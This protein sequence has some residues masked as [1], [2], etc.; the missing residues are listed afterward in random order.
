MRAP[1]LASL[2][3]AV[4]VV[5][6]LGCTATAQP[7]SNAAREAPNVKPAGAK[8]VTVA[9]TADPYTLSS[10]V[11]AA[12]TGIVPGLDQIEQLVHTG[13]A[14]VAANG[15]AEPVIAEA[16]PTVE[17]G[18][19][20]LLPD[21]RMETT[22]T[23]R[24]GAT[25]HDGTPFT[26]DDL[27]FTADVAGD[28]DLP[29][30]RDVAQK[31]IE[32]VSARD[33]R[34]ITVT[35]NRP[36]V[37]A[38]LMFT[39]ALA[40]PLPKHLLQ[41][42]YADDKAALF[43]NPYFSTEFVGAGPFKIQS[44]ERDSY[45]RLTA[46]DGY[47]LGRPKLDEIEVRFFPDPNALIAGILAGAVDV[48]LGRGLSVD[49]AVQIRDQWADGHMDVALWAP[50]GMYPQQL[51][52][53]PAILGDA[54]FRR[55]LVHAIDR[56][57]M[58][59]T[60]VAGQSP[61]AHSFL[62]PDEAEYAATERSVVRYDYDARR[63]AQ[64]LDGLGL[65]R[66]QDGMYRNSDGSELALEIR[67]VISTDIN[68]KSMLAIADY[69]QRAGLRTNTM[70]IPVS[71]A[72]EREFRATFPGFDL[73]GGVGGNY[74]WL[75][76]LYSSQVPTSETRWVGRNKARYADPAL[77]RLIDRFFATV[78][79]TERMD[80]LN[81]IVH[82]LTDQV[83]TIGLFYTAQPTMVANKV[84]NVSGKTAVLAA[85]TWNAHE[86]DL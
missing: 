69:W 61:V 67:S 37:Q 23:I 72:R 79:R 43:D 54:R 22:W 30:S 58:V 82:Q 19:W 26:T 60:L 85:T 41:Q 70:P 66:G 83:V 45:L 32:G 76:R 71:R 40:M 17:N 50:T 1:N 33:A 59:A 27:R 20:V 25:W 68:N 46:F 51:N 39:N 57:A 47:V 21:G 52:P 74:T 31:A 28:P 8:R 48:T 16:V 35:W 36:Y 53:N 29:L 2:A 65:V 10:S 11:N 12:T 80:V 56:E 6:T 4:L 44:W 63:A 78:Q 5:L 55:A 62:A 73:S 7:A 38:D 18:L 84:K 86:W 24:S 3:A 13:L 49:Q 42:A 14:H 34:T 64:I 15:I 77:D 9:V 81:T 75:E